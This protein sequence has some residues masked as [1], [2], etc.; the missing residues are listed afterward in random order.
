[1][2]KDVRYALHSDRLDPLL[3]TGHYG[4]G[5]GERRHS[6]DIMSRNAFLVF[7]LDGSRA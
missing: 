5:V 6:R 2:W 4:L 7:G 3:E 1:M